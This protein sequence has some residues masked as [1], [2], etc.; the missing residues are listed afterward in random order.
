MLRS[1][2]RRSISTRHA[3]ELRNVQRLCPLQAASGE[4][5]EH[6]LDALGLIEAPDRHEHRAGEAFEVGGEQARAAIPAEIPV[7]AFA[8]CGDVVEGLWLAARQREVA[9]GDAE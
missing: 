7:E 1:S 5:F 9:L 8:R 2:G 4:H 3:V 6:G